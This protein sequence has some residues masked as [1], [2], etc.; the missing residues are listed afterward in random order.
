MAPPKPKPEDIIA[1]QAAP[2]AKP[3][4]VGEVATR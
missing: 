2:K 3:K 4:P 1:G